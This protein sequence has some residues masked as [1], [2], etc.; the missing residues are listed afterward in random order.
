MKLSE[1]SRFSILNI[2]KDIYYGDGHVLPAVNESEFF[3]E[4]P[5]RA[6]LYFIHFLKI[7]IQT[8][9]KCQTSSTLYDVI[10]SNM[11]SMEFARETSVTIRSEVGILKAG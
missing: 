1:Y 7:D 5:F 6:Y 2:T 9:F 3:L 11:G 10:C 8:S 4:T